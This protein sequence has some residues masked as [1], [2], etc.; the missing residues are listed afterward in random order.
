MSH[1][2]EANHVGSHTQNTHCMQCPPNPTPTQQLI[3][4]MEDEHSNAITLNY[5]MCRVLLELADEQS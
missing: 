3:S 2:F 1:Q 4:R 5:P